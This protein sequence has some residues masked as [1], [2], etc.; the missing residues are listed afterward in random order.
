MADEKPLGYD[1]AL[2]AAQANKSQRYIEL[3]ELQRWVDGTQ[4][5]S[6]PC[7]WFD[8]TV[9]LWERRPCVVYPAAKIAIDSYVDLIFGEGR[10]PAFTT[11]P[12][13]DEGDEVGGLGEDDSAALDRLITEIGKATEFA[14]YCREALEGAMGMC[15]AVGVHGVRN[16]APFVETIPAKW[17]KPKFAVTGEVVELE[18]RYPYI[19]ETRDERGRTVA[20]AKLYRRV[21]DALSDTTFL[22]AVA[23]PQGIEPKWV[24]DPERTVTHGFGFCPVVWYPHMRGTVA[25]NVIDGKAIH[26]KVRDEIREHDIARSQWHRCALFSEPQI[27]EMGVAPGHNPTGEGRPA[28]VK[29]SEEGGKITAANPERGG[30]IEGPASAGARKKGPGYPWQYPSPDTDVKVLETS[31]NA[32]EAQHTNVSDLRMRLQEAMSVVFLDPNNI[33]FAA[34]TSGK[35]LEAIKQK[36]LDRCAQIRDDVRARLL[37]PSISIQLRIVHKVREGMRVPGVKKALAVLDKL[38]AD[39]FRIPS[40]ALKWGPYFKPDPTEQNAQAT[41]VRTLRGNAQAG[42]EPLVTRRQAVEMLQP[43]TGAEN[44][45]AVLAALDEEDAAREEKSR[46]KAE[47]EAKVL[48]DAASAGADRGGGEGQPPKAPGGRGGGAAAAQA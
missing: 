12:A 38:A 35:A 24:V 13:E 47:H 16:G 28:M 48:H 7:G 37:I 31:E 4:Y 40:L 42:D 36:Q 32:L 11:K 9:P 26:D 19:D 8:D 20:T 33:K 46:A 25:V 34:T 18:I 22:P 41:M 23:H 45:D 15:T 6:R 10:F 21:I 29:A 3:E 1:D 30:Y 5:D 39:G 43:I 2:K 27:V 14:A 17:C 44:V